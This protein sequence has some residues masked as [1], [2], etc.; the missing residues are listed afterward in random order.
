M[1]FIIIF[2]FLILIIGLFWPLWLFFPHSLFIN[3]MSPDLLVAESYPIYRIHQNPS[4]IRFEVFLILH[5][6]NLFDCFQFL[7]D[8][9]LVKNYLFFKYKMQ[10]IFLS[11]RK[12][13]P[14]TGTNIYILIKYIL[15]AQ[16][17]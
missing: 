5:F 2:I 9:L 1:L 11:L 12:Y 8:Q 4:L 17:F 13:M 15:K 16:S 3:V 14:F 7:S 6:I 10:L